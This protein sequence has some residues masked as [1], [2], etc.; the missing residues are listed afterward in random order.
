MVASVRLLQTCPYPG[1][2]HVLGCW[3]MLLVKILHLKKETLLQD[4]VGIFCISSTAFVSH[5]FNSRPE[6]ALESAS[7]LINVILFALPAPAMLAI[8]S[9][10]TG[11]LIKLY[12][13]LSL[14]GSLGLL[15]L[16]VLS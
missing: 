6:S 8:I 3:L 13:T 9:V 10:M 5:H 15:S 7:T 14:S 12:L 16:I 2:D 4:L 11:T 1:A